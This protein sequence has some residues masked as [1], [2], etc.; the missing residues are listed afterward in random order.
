MKIVNWLKIC[1]KML[2]ASRTNAHMKET[3]EELGRLVEAAV[4][5]NQ[6]QIDNPKVKS[7]I[8]TIE[9]CKKDLVH[10]EKQVNKIRFAEKHA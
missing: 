8:H 7:L 5:D 4:R 10:L 2:T 6:L 1:R 9:A 3:Y